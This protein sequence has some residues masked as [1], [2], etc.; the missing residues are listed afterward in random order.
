KWM[1]RLNI[2]TARRPHHTLEEVGRAIV[3]LVEEDLLSKWGRGRIIHKLKVH[4]GIQDANGTFVRA[5]HVA[6]DPGSALV[7]APGKHKKVHRTSLWSLGPSE[8]WSGDGHDKLARIGLPIWGLRDKATRRVLGL[9]V[10]PNSRIRIVPAAL[11]L[12]V[13]RDVGGVPMKVTLDQGSEGGILGQ[14]QTQLRLAYAPDLDPIAL[15]AF[16]KI[17]SVYN[18]T[19]E[20][21]WRFLYE[22]LL[23]SILEA[24]EVGV[25]AGIYHEAL[26]LEYSVAR[27]LWARLVQQELDKYAMERN[28]ARIRRQARV[29]L[30]TG[31]TPNEFWYHPDCWSMENCLIPVAEEHIEQLLRENTPPGLF[32]FVSDEMELVCSELYVAV[33]SPVLSILSTWDVYTRMVS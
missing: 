8:E 19:I 16:E 25:R 3:E 21:S 28:S 20:R 24:W 14:L 13:V 7:R 32:Q 18:I 26:V 6:L 27:W 30:P 23:E 4:K 22:N 5:F 29:H 11:Y 17:K 12:R 9:W 33:G 15:P 1:A 31:D 2:A 10:V